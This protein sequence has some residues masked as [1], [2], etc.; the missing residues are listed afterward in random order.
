[1]ALFEEAITT[2]RRSNNHFNQQTGQG[3]INGNPQ[4]LPNQIKQT[5]SP[6]LDT[7]PDSNYIKIGSYS[8]PP[9][10]GNISKLESPTTT[11][12]HRCPSSPRCR[13]DLLTKWSPVI[14]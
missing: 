7:S 3:Y 11:M 14:R 10:G 12:Q 8:N 2:R 13:F 6:M 4:L 9:L 1:M 5:T